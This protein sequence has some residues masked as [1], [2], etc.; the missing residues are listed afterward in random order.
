MLTG[1]TLTFFPP[2][3]TAGTTTILLT[4]GF[5]H[6][7][8]VWDG[9]GVARS[10]AVDGGPV[11]VPVGEQDGDLDGAHTL[12]GV[13]GTVHSGIYII[14]TFFILPILVITHGMVLRHG[15]EPGAC[16]P[17]SRP[18]PGQINLH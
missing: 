12:H 10:T 8:S 17:D 16:A 4:G 6:R 9:I 13:L 14:H 3:Q 15:K 18:T 1:D 2:G 5:G 11:G 7:V